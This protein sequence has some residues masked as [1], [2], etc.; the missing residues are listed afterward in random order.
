MKVI[1][2]KDVRGLGKRGEVREVNDGYAKNRLI[3]GKFAAQATPGALAANEHARE[4][5]NEAHAL[6][7]TELKQAAQMLEGKVLVFKRKMNDKGEAFG[8]VSEHDIE[9]SISALGVEVKLTDKKSIKTAGE[10]EVKIPLGEGI[11]ANVKVR[12]EADL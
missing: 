8:S 2:L 12:L 5:Q 1:L 7:I 4:A 3:P 9:E 10:Y 6:H 11:H